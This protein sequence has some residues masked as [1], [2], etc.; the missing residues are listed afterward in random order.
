MKTTNQNKESEYFDNAKIK[1][2]SLGDSKTLILFDVTK[3]NIAYVAT[4]KDGN[5]SALKDFNIKFMRMD[6]VYL[7][8]FV[9]LPFNMMYLWII[10]AASSCCFCCVGCACM[11]PNLM[12]ANMGYCGFYNNDE[13]E[14]SYVRI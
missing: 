9:S 8:K 7:A 3:I 14:G 2:L 4:H 13:E 10:I 12:K 5:N 6:A 11:H 1:A